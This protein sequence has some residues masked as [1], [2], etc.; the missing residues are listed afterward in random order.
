MKII[1]IHTHAFPDSIA[2]KAMSALTENSGD[3]KPFIGGT[4]ND[5][6]K[7]MGNSNID[8]A[9][10]AN[11]AT[12]PEQFE[13]IMKWS[14]SIQ[15]NKIIPLGSVHPKSAN[16]KNE[17]ALIKESNF[18]GIKLHPMY[19]DF[20]IDDKKIY[21]LYEYASQSNLF[22]LIHSGYDIAFPGNE[23]ASPN[24]ILNVIKD[25]PDLKIIAAH[26]GGWRSWDK[27]VEY[28]VGKNVYFDTSFIHE[29]DDETI[30]KIFN[31]HDS[32]LILFGTDSPWLDQKR[33]VENIFKLKIN[34]EL[35]EKIF[36]KNVVN[37]TNIEI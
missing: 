25:F 2:E 21:P 31:N 36:F 3:Y 5:L 11:I 4:I 19:Q 37:L 29:V 18:P 32:N 16:L 26:L 14:K 24:K 17:I 34:D 23:N 8:A 6:L 1:D 20:E 9:F 35:K 13:P 27:V 33:E 12:K 22:I 28:L 30:Y 7:S 15:T 10:I